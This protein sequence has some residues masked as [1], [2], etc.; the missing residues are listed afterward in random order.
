VESKRIFIG[1][2]GKDMAG[3]AAE[4]TSNLRRRGLYVDIEVS[5]RTLR[6]QLEY[7]S[8]FTSLFVIVG[9]RDYAERKVT[10]RDMES[11]EESKILLEQLEARLRSSL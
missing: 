10:L 8:K 5:G 2:V 3:V 9:P 11:G 1:Y 7:A 6:K 4:I